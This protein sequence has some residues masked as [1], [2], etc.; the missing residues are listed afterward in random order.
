MLEHNRGVPHRHVSGGRGGVKLQ[1]QGLVPPV[2]GCNSLRPDGGDV[3]PFVELPVK[4]E[5]SVEVQS[6]TAAVIHHHPQFF[7]L[8]GVRKKH[9]ARGDAAEKLQS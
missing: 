1:L 3:V 7:P 2:E 9:T 6:Q 8:W 5:D 4:G